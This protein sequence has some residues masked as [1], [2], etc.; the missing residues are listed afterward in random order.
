MRGRRRIEASEPGG[1]P[2]K[3]ADR[4]AVAGLRAAEAE[5]EAEAEAPGTGAGRT[6]G[7]GSLRG[8]AGRSEG[9]CGDLPGSI[10]DGGGR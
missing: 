10:A 9:W 5:A 4:F 8:G 7:E 2:Q 1:R 6:G 3:R